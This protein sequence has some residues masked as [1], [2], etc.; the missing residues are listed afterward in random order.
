MALG[1]PRDKKE[2]GAGSSL[3]LLRE[4]REEGNNDYPRG[5]ESTI[6]GAEGLSWL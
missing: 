1:D 4:G 6:P 2:G 5:T 3:A